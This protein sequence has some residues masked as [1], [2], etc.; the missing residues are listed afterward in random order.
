MK[1]DLDLVRQILQALEVQEVGRHPGSAFAIEERDQLEVMF[2]VHLMEQAGLVL[3]MRLGH[4]GEPIP[5]AFPTSI[6]WAGYEFLDASRDNKIWAKAKKHVI[7]PAG[8]V[9][10]SFLLEWLKAEAKNRLGL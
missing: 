8:S 5:T 2:H 1:R 9:S 6:T 3:A 7:E 10:F 4:V